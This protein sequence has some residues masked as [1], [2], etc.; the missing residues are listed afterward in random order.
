MRVPDA[1]TAL[2]LTNDSSLGLSG[3]IWSRDPKKASAL[4]R[5][6]EAGS[7]CVNDVL[8][9][10]MY[11]NAPLGGVKAS[12]LGIRHGSEALRQFCRTQTVIEDRPLFSGISALVAKWLGFPYQRNLL[13]VMRWL[14]K[15]LY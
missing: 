5:R 11:V 6:I 14:M 13:Q 9:N 10:Y 12:G 4:A 1:E 15:R 7:V 2:R 8:F 3:S